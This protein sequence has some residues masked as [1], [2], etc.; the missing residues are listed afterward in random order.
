MFDRFL[1]PVRRRIRERSATRG[2]CERLTVR[3]LKQTDDGTRRGIGRGSI[4]VGV[5]EVRHHEGTAGEDAPGVPRNSRNT[6]SIGDVG[7]GG[8]NPHRRAKIN[9][10]RVRCRTVDDRDG[11]HAGIGRRRA[12]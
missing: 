1:I 7:D 11:Y 10:C 9:L 2:R 6:L 5:D 4:L 12:S 8:I 3:G